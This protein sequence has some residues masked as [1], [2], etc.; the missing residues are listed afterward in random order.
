[1]PWAKMEKE[2]SLW[3]KCHKILFLFLVLY[4]RGR[5]LAFL[6]TLTLTLLARYGF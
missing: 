4:P 1:M 2:Q 3:V 6:Q 5:G